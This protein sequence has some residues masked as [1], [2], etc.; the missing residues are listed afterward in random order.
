MKATRRC[1]AP[2]AV[3][4]RS[5]DVPRHRSRRRT[6]TTVVFTFNQVYHPGPVRHRRAEHRPGAHLE[7]HRGSGDL[8]QREPGRHRPVHRDRR[9]SRT[10]TTNAKNPNY[11]QEG[12]PYIDGFRF[13]AYPSNDAGQP[14]DGQRRDRLSPPT[15]SP[16]SRRS[17]SPRTRSTSTTGSHRPAPSSSS[18][19]TRPRRRSTTSTCARRSAW[20]STAT[21]SSWSRCTT[22][23]TRPTPPA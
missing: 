19:P 22:T 15:S 8:H 12:K 21:R 20:R 17:T 11:W 9:R 16:T 7:G 13:P 18:T 2:K 4:R 3:P 1:R 6:T 23:P 5:L 14:G 10:S